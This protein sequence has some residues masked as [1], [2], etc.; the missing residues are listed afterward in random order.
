MASKQQAALFLLLLLG[1]AAACAAQSFDALP[2]FHF[3][4]RVRLAVEREAA[5]DWASLTTAQ[6][7][8]LLLLQPL[9]HPVASWC[10]W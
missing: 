1:L 2:Q 7:H 4:P 5:G 6:S 3:V 8:V 10:T 9:W